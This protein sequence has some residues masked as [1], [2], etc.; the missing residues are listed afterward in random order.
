MHTA[1][2]VIKCKYFDNHI[3]SHAAAAPPDSFSIYQLTPPT[4]PFSTPLLFAP[5]RY[6]LRT[7]SLSVVSKTIWASK[8]CL[9]L[10]SRYII[11]E[12]FARRST[13]ARMQM[14]MPK[15]KRKPKAEPAA[16]WA[17]GKIKNESP[18]PSL[19]HS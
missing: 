8:V 18:L 4:Q 9:K 1:K 10:P 5:I 15:P 6:P 11:Q 12:N 7:W 16:S 17:L 3:V 14:Q 19:L 13:G 2:L